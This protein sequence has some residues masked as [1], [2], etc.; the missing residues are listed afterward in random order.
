MTSGFP[1]RQSPASVDSGDRSKYVDVVF[2][3]CLLIGFLFA[4]IYAKLLDIYF[5][6]PP[7]FMPHTHTHTQIQ[8]FTHSYK[9]IKWTNWKRDKREKRHTRQPHST[10][11]R[12]RTKRT[13]EQYRPCRR[14]RPHRSSDDPPQQRHNAR[15]FGS[16]KTKQ[17]NNWK[18]KLKS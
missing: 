7:S 18:K 3:S 4:V 9:R 8:K 6:F 13:R 11:T 10:P 5:F 2:I 16:E 1:Y 15:Y 17:E 12:R 14:L